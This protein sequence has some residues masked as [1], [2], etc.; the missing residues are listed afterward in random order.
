MRS[1][2]MHGR[3]PLILQTEAAECG[4]ACLA[5]IAGYHGHQ[6]D[7]GTLRR[8]YPISL[9]GATLRSL[10]NVAK[11]LHFSCRS[12]RLE[13]DHLHQLQLPAIL[14][15]D[16]DHFVVLKKVSGDNLILHDPGCGV[17][18]TGLSE[19]GKHLTGIAVELFPAEDFVPI[20]E[21]DRLRLSVFW[22]HMRRTS[23]ALLQVFVL[24]VILELFVIAS[25]QAALHRKISRACRE[26][27]RPAPH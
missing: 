23:H 10:V 26:G 15:W 3:L 2:G 21:R 22:P 4:L 16:M 14:H 1:F 17:K 25:P 20:D 19:A 9:K 24:S 6:I 13:P 27:H 12:L 5:M 7:I 11:D 18:Q 8:R